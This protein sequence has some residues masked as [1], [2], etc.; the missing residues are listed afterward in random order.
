MDDSIHI[1]KISSEALDS[2]LDLLERFFHEEG[3]D[4][5]VAQIRVSLAVMLISQ[6]SAVFLARQDGAALGVATVTTS[7]GLEYGL[8]AEIEDLYVLPQARGRG[9]ASA[10]IEAACNWCRR[11]GCSL[12]LVTVTPQGDDAHGLMDFYQQ[13]GFVNTRRVLLERSLITLEE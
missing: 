10:L 2:A 8:S 11:K 7:L 6:L 5:P 4:T 12:V 3:F 9:I 1:E 13:R